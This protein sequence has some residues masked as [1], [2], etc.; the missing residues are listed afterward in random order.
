MALVLFRP[1]LFLFDPLLSRASI[2]VVLSHSSS[3]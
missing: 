3:Q 2:L 1:V